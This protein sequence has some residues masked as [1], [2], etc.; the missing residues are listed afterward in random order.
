MRRRHTLPVHAARP[1]SGLIL[2][3]SP[4]EAIDE[5]GLLALLRHL[6]ERRY[7][8]VSPTPA[9]HA[10]ILARMEHRVGR[11]VRD[12]LGWSLPFAPGSI[13]PVE[14]MLE[15]AGILHEAGGLQASSIRVSSL[16]G[17]LFAHS[18]YPTSDVRSVFFGPD[19]YRFA[20]FIAA[21]LPAAAAGGMRIVDMGGGAGVGAIVMRDLVPSATIAM[22]DINPDA[23][24][25]ARI[26]AAAAGV[27]V[28]VAEAPDLSTLSGPFDIVTANPPYIVDDMGRAYRDGGDMHGARV[29]LDMAA[30]AIERLAP[31]GR[32]ILYTGSAIVAGRDALGEALRGLCEARGLALTYR[33]LDPDVFG[34][35][36]DRSA[37]REVERIAL[38]GA[39]VDRP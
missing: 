10:R 6:E 18:A 29:S 30:A 25:L 26:N 24:R 21:S 7:R 31:G 19:S 1:C 39:F 12:V 5:G 16:R 33:E 3:G 27:T 9:T 34:E 23:I 17:R 35:E 2:A 13:G 22:T 32:L 4:L 11:N 20:D 36:L 37:Y 28:E 14:A 38:V 8:F 15:A